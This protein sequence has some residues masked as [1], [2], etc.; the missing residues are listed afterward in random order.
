[1]KTFFQFLFES[2]NT[3]KKPSFQQTYETKRRA[4]IVAQKDNI[5]V[6]KNRV[7]QQRIEQDEQ[8]DDDRTEKLEKEMNKREK[9]RKKIADRVKKEHDIDLEDYEN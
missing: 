3:N 4:G 7:K 6:N 5:L 8:E 9:T 1:M 2:K